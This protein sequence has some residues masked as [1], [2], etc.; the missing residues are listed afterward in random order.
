[1]QN[2]QGQATPSRDTGKTVSGSAAS[3]VQ[4]LKNGSATADGP[5]HTHSTKQ[6]STPNAGAG[7]AT[8]SKH[9]SVPSSIPGIGP[10]V[11]PSASYPIDPDE[12]YQALLDSTSSSKATQVACGMLLCAADETLRDSLCG[13]FTRISGAMEAWV[14]V[15]KRNPTLQPVFGSA[16]AHMTKNASFSSS[17]LKI[18]ATMNLFKHCPSEEVLTALAV[19]LT[20]SAPRKLFLH[21]KGIETLNEILDR[22]AKSEVLLGALI[23]CIRIAALTFPVGSTSAAR[24]GDAER[25]SFLAA[26]LSG[27]LTVKGTQLFRIGAIRYQGQV[28]QESF[29][30]FLASAST[31]EAG[32]QGSTQCLLRFIEEILPLDGGSAVDENYMSQLLHSLLTITVTPEKFRALSG[33]STIDRSCEVPLSPSTNTLLLHL[34]AKWISQHQR[35]FPIALCALRALRRES[36]DPSECAV[37]LGLGLAILGDPDQR[38]KL[39]QGLYPSA[40]VGLQKML[41][42]PQPADLVAVR[43]CRKYWICFVHVFTHLIGF[44]LAAFFK[45]LEARIQSGAILESEFTQMTNWPR[46]D[47]ADSLLVQKITAFL[48]KLD[49]LI[50]QV[51]DTAAA[52]AREEDLERQRLIQIFVKTAN[53][54]LLDPHYAERLERR[55]GTFADCESHLSQISSE[56]ETVGKRI[57]E[58]RLKREAALRN[59]MSRL[60]ET[61]LESYK[62]EMEGIVWDPD[63]KAAKHQAHTAKLS[64]IAKTYEK[65]ISDLSIHSSWRLDLLPKISQV[66][67]EHSKSTNKELLVL[68]FEEEQ[69]RG[70]GWVSTEAW[71]QQKPD[72]LIQQEAKERETL[73]KE[74][75]GGLVL[76]ADGSVSVVGDFGASRNGIGSLNRVSAPFQPGS[77]SDATRHLTSPF[78]GLTSISDPGDFLLGSPPTPP[79]P[80]KLDGP[81]LQALLYLDHEQRK[82][83]VNLQQS[84]HNWR[85]YHFHCFAVEEF[86]MTGNQFLAETPRLQLCWY[87]S[88]YR[89]ELET[90]QSN[91]REVVEKYIASCVSQFSITSLFPIARLPDESSP[92]D[93]VTPT[94]TGGTPTANLNGS[95]ASPVSFSLPQQSQTDLF[96]TLMM[97]E[98]AGRR[99]VVMVENQWWVYIV[100]NIEYEYQLITPFLM[101]SE[102]E[103]QER[104]FWDAEEVKAWYL[105][106][107]FRPRGRKY[108]PPRD[109]PIM[110]ESSSLPISQLNRIKNWQRQVIY[111]TDDP[112]S[113]IDDGSH[114]PPLPL[115]GETVEG[116]YPL[117]LPNQSASLTELVDLGSNPSRSDS[118]GGIG[119]GVG[120]RPCEN[121][122]DEGNPAEDGRRSDARSVGR[123]A[124]PGDA[125][126][127][128]G[129]KTEDDSAVAVVSSPQFESAIVALESMETYMRHELIGVRRRYLSN[130]QHL[131]SLLLETLNRMRQ[132]EQ[133]FDE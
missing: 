131:Q 27:L 15:V 55:K 29:S 98:V 28:F 133:M 79:I 103:R 58:A 130:A 36:T 46:N 112:L 122:T 7:T 11:V 77:T 38:K 132:L 128:L 116:S 30:A 64:K 9:R 94:G 96:A 63:E 97:Q 2:L 87:E 129:Q 52:I 113:I 44:S 107:N 54:F 83:F 88:R 68:E 8:T 39:A 78:N 59:E 1:M 108:R 37:A 125:F 33:L 5:A 16:F 57:A 102:A 106:Q 119:G 14:S 70:H 22:L 53:Q 121:A 17:V 32:A 104:G 84:E 45:P 69:C 115:Q 67:K 35:R 21:A 48:Q 80:P 114:P 60:R 66:F 74:F 41:E 86:L 24:V 89:S 26:C 91:R 123:A 111:S 73:M 99:Q 82:S 10:Q 100:K 42:I 34:L 110:E 13:V 51:E 127:A 43:S 93:R 118:E 126:E 23:P 18:R 72:S 75:F 31:S 62:A 81:R 49:P 65:Q 50:K 76:S 12:V 105:L 92:I 85:V 19:I 101:L 56:L 20:D 124:S 120:E 95:R 40:L 71:R 6:S 3:A 61:Q 25:T 117:D 109:E 90:E 47:A 4:R